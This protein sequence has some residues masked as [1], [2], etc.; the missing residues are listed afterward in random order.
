MFICIW[1]LYVSIVQ[2]ICIIYII[3]CVVLAV[4][5]Y[6]AVCIIYVT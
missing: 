6:I 1:M 2:A 5:T 4:D 3:V